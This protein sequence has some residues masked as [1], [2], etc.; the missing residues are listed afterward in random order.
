RYGGRAR[1]RAL[2][3]RLLPDR[4]GR[5]AQGDEPNRRDGARLP[6]VEPDRRGNLGLPGLGEGRRVATRQALPAG[7]RGRLLQRRSVGSTR[8]PRSKTSY[9]TPTQKRLRRKD[10]R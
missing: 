1:A 9:P 3:L 4:R 7:R 2:G 6:V 10:A 8:T 5:R